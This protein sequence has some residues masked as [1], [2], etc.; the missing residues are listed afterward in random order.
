MRNKFASW[1]RRYFLRTMATGLF[2]AAGC[3]AF[4]GRP[5]ECRR[6]IPV[7]GWSEDYRDQNLQVQRGDG[8]GDP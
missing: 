7:R 3:T 6:C 8:T 5:R 2:G 1:D 4:Q